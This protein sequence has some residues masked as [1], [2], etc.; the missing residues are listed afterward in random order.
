MRRRRK[1]GLT[2]Q[3][4]RLLRLKYDRVLRQ[5]LGHWP[6]LSQAQLARRMQLR[7]RTSITNMEKGR[8]FVTEAEA[9]R[10]LDAMMAELVQQATGVEVDYNP[11]NWGLPP[12]PVDRLD[13]PYHNRPRDPRGRWLPRGVEG[14]YPGARFSIP[15]VRL[16]ARLS[17][18]SPPDTAPR[19]HA[20][21]TD[22]QLYQ[23]APTPSDST[24]RDQIQTPGRPPRSV[25]EVREALKAENDRQR[26]ERERGDEVTISDI[27]WQR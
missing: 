6:G 9:F 13:K 21:M 26:M 16:R 24:K 14:S 5:Q 18:S 15:E 17:R 27:R 8:V 22:D 19:E 3:S 23:A 2:G 7:S 20:V 1:Y 4:L 25:A 12:E 10:V 11:Q